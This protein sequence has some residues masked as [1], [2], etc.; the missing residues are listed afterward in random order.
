MTIT[1][2]RNRL[3]RLTGDLRRAQCDGNLD[4]VDRIR[5]KFDEALDEYN[6]S[7]Q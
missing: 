1:Q 6:R 5:K 3:A 7:Q 4:E 2:Y